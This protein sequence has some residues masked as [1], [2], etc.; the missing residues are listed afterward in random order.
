MAPMAERERTVMPR[1]MPS[2]RVTRKPS[3]LF[4]VVVR[5]S[6]GRRSGI[7]VSVVEGKARHGQPDDADQRAANHVGRPMHAKVNP[8]V[9][10]REHHGDDDVEWPPPSP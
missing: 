9:E 10:A 6:G 7:R 8:R 3:R 4:A 1:T 2:V 5:N